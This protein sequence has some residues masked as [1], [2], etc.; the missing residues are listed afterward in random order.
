MDDPGSEVKGEG[1]GMKCDEGRRG[2]REVGRRERKWRG[3]KRLG[4]T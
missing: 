3:R 2:G 1:G 4:V